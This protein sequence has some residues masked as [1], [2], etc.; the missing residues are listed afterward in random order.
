MQLLMVTPVH[1]G[2]VHSLKNKCYKTLCMA[3]STKQIIIII[4][5]LFLEKKEW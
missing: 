5:T 3:A 2:H 1:L 4:P